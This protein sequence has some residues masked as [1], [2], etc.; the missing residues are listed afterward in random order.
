MSIFSQNPTVSKNS[1]HYELLDK[2]YFDQDKPKSQCSYFWTVLFLIITYP[3]WSVGLKVG[4]K[5]D[6]LLKNMGYGLGIIASYVIALLMIEGLIGYIIGFISP[7]FFKSIVYIHPMAEA[8]KRG[9][10]I[11]GSITLTFIL[12]DGISIAIA[13]I[14]GIVHVLSHLLKKSAESY[15]RLINKTKTKEKKDN[16]LTFIGSFIGWI[17]S[18]K[19]KI[20]KPIIYINETDSE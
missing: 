15:N 12:V 1:W 3:L 8:G 14:F 9:L 7:E 11:F 6:G 17:T 10:T 18:K 4:F 16:N 2:V 20:C 13:L 5:K 19:Q